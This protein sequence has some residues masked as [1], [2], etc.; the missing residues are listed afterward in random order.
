LKSQLNEK[1]SFDTQLKPKREW[2]VIKSKA[3][4]CR[5]LFERPV[6]WASCFRS[7]ASGFWLMEKYDFIVLNWWCLNEVRIRLVLCPVGWPDN[8]SEEPVMD[9]WPSLIQPVSRFEL[10]FDI[11]LLSIELPFVR[12]RVRK[13]KFSKLNTNY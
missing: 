6:F 1:K 5:T 10:R 13:R 12:E 7:L 4:T 8:P 2:N 11:T 3:H 9:D